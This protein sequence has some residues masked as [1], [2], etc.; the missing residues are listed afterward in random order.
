V[1]CTVCDNEVVLGNPPVWSYRQDIYICTCCAMNEE[2]DIAA[3]AE[4]VEE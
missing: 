2:D 3:E 4:M 1:L